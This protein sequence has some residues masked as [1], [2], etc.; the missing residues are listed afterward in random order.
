MLIKIVMS[1]PVNKMRNV[2]YVCMPVM[3]CLGSGTNVMAFVLPR[4]I[5]WMSPVDDFFLWQ[6]SVR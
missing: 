2:C 4:I 1:V 3:L 5:W 6:G